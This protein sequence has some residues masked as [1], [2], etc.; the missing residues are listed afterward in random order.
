[1]FIINQYLDKL[2]KINNETAVNISF[3]NFVWLKKIC[4]SQF[5][6]YILAVQ[7]INIF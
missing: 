4:S 5:T 1:M 7:L 6:F 3:D 2:V